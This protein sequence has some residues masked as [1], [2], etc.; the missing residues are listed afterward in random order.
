VLLVD[1]LGRRRGLVRLSAPAA[2][3]PLVARTRR[4][5]TPARQLQLEAETLANTADLPQPDE[6]QWAAKGADSDRL[7]MATA[8]PVHG[9]GARAAA[10]SWASSSDLPRLA[11]TAHLQL[12]QQP[13]WGYLQPPPGQ[14]FP[15]QGR[16]PWPV[17]SPWPQQAPAPTGPQPVSTPTGLHQVSV[18]SRPGAPMPTDMSWSTPP[19]PMAAGISGVTLAAQSAG[20]M[21]SALPGPEAQPMIDAT[22]PGQFQPEPRSQAAE[23]ETAQ[24]VAQPQPEPRSSSESLN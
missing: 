15:V 8:G 21:A 11:S 5:W 19:T 1:W 4:F 12:V 2:L 6:H 14:Q 9:S 18:P 7:A 22:T 24:P 13:V 10:V 20:A 23:P 16:P 17:P 3:R